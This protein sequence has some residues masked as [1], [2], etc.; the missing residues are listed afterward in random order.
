MVAEKLRSAEPLR[1]I[2]AFGRLG[3]AP[4]ATSTLTR[5]ASVALFARGLS[6]RRQYD[7]F[8][9]GF[10]YNAVSGKF[11]ND[12]EHL[13]GTTVKNEK[14]IE[15]FYDF[16]ITPAIRVNP[17]YQHIWNPLIAGVAVKQN[18]ADLFLARLNVAF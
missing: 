15:I 3:Y 1:G 11:K 14:G 9:M 6:D 13:T 2:G 16:A 18:H 8:G 17:G 10:Y 7:S 12:I 4:D 5:E